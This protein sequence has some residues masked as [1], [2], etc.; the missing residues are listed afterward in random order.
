MVSTAAVR[1]YIPSKSRVQARNRNTSGCWVLGTGARG[2]KVLRIPT[3][4]SLK[5][6]ICPRWYSSISWETLSA[7]TRN[8]LCLT[9]IALH[10]KF[11]NILSINRQ[12]WRHV[13]TGGRWLEW[14][15]ITQGLLLRDIIILHGETFPPPPIICSLLTV[16]H[17]LPDLKWFGCLL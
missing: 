10:S 8:V 3:C 17:V 11:A 1:T 2:K 15:S 16:T 7:S 5:S 6:G 13:V 9:H 12:Q 4:Q 14:V